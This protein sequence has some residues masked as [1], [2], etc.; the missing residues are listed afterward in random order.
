MGFPSWL[1]TYTHGLTVW[2]PYRSFDAIAEEYFT[3]I[4]GESGVLAR[5]WLQELS[6]RFDPPYLRHEKPRRSDAHVRRYRELEADIR[7]KLPELEALAE[8]SEQWAR[9]V[10]HGKLCAQLAHALSL[11][12]AE[13][14]TVRDAV[15]K[16]KE[17]AYDRYWEAY[18]YMDVKFYTSILGNVLDASDFE[19]AR[20]VETEG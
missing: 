19:F 15:A 9:L 5:Q 3:A 10:H 8:N 12:A 17:M 1:P 20:E 16:L 7:R 2:D 6:D 11:Y 14:P 4:F 18:D 13:D